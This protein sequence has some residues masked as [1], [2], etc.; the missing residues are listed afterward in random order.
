MA[1]DSS[2]F[3]D[4]GATSEISTNLA[5]RAIDAETAKTAAEA[6][7]VAA[8]TAASNAEASETA[9]Q[10]SADSAATSSATAVTSA[11]TATTKASE[12]STSASNASTSASE[13]ATS[14]TNAATSETNSATSATSASTSATAAQTA[15]TAAETAKTAAETAQTAAE[16]AKT[17]AETA[18]TNAT[19]ASTSAS[20]SSATATTQA[21]TATTKA[22]EAATSATNAATSEANAATSETNA[23]TSA[24]NAAASATNAATSETNSATSETN[25]ATSETNAA[26]S[27]STASTQAGIATTKASEASSSATS[28]QTAQTA[29]ETAKTASETAQTAAETAKTAAETA[30]TNASNSAS[31]ALTSQ[32]NAATSA[33]NAATSATAASASQVAAAASAA[34][35][36]AA[37]DTFDDRY[38]GTKTSNPTVDNDGD[39]LVE[40]ALYFNSTANEMRVYDGANWIAASSAGTASLNNYH[41]TA[42]AAQT[43]FSGADDNSATLSYTVN[44]LIVTLNGVVLEDG[45]DYTATNGTSVVLT[46]GAALNDEVNIV[47]FKSFTT[48]DMV[49]ATN[50]GTFQNDITI[51]GDLTVD[52]NTLFVD[53]ASGDVFIDG[54]GDFVVGASTSQYKTANRA[55]IEANGAST[56]LV[57]LGIADDQGGYIFH[58]GTNMDVANYKNGDLNFITNNTTRATIDSSGNV[59]IGTGSPACGLHVD[60]PDNGAITAILDTDNSAVK[61]IFRNN[62][63]TG[64]NIQIGADGSNLVA[65]TGGSERMRLTSDGRLGLGTSSP[66]TVSGFTVLEVAGSSNGGFIQVTNGT[67]NNSFYNSGNVGFIGTQTNHSLGLVTNGSERLRVDSSGGIGGNTVGPRGDIVFTSGT[68]DSSKRWGFGGA[69][70]S[71]SNT[72]FYIINE[73]NIGQYMAHGAQT[74][75]AHS[76]ERIKENITNVGEVLPSLLNMRCVKYNLIS[77]PENTKIGFIAQDWEA[78][79]P[80]VVDED[81]HLVLEDDGTIGTD[82]NSDSETPVKAMSYTETIPLLLKAIQEQQV[83]IDDLKSRIEALENA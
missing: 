4:S 58:D 61:M 67:V 52:T 30:E 31:S 35:A 55:V 12:A 60:N 3:K 48:A 81:A 34:S 50:G 23:A 45:T 43:T 15:Q 7:K 14:A 27:A 49:S 5:Q 25:A 28:A 29:S 75:T 19:S 64:N 70:G 38:L 13:A 21:S 18:E 20:N 26:T 17:S 66:S 72:S 53:S 78:S 76:D 37:Y 59:G 69:L 62:T 6:A 68:Q 32:T 56:S 36:A 65:L 83:I 63:E 16:A 46:S 9:V 8:E 1:N 79:F 74:W 42:T 71:G 41:Y 47:A 44:N 80:E 10:A 54:G 33:T 57:A 77:N 24:S 73:G 51:S 39:A 82:D 11:A 40:G 2:F 22:G